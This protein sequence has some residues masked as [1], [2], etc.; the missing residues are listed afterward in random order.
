LPADSPAKRIVDR[1]LPRSGLPV[2]A[3]FAAIVVVL[4][5]APHLP[6]R[7]GLALDGVAALLGGGWCATN[8]WRCRHAHCLITSA[9]WLP[10][11][12]LAFVEAV[13]GRSLIGGNEQ[14]VFL[15]VLGAGIAFEAAW[16]LTHG[17]NA[18]TRISI[19]RTSG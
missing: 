11:S 14:I 12:G 8:F 3:Y 6:S 16:Q 1:V 10:V 5:L 4:N 2:L 19:R 7:A 17:S 15:A 9:G 18:V 13:I